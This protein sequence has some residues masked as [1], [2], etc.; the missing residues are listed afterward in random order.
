MNEKL[1][2]FFIEQGFKKLMEFVPGFAVYFIME[3]RYANAVCLIDQTDH[4]EITAEQYEQITKKISWRFVDGGCLDVHMLSLI[5]T[6]DENAAM[7][8]SGD[9]AFCWLILR[10]ENRLLIPEGRAEDFYGMKELLTKCLEKPYAPKGRLEDPVIY[11]ARGQQFYKSIKERPLVN[12][13]IFIINAL[14]F[15]ACILTGDFLYDRGVLSRDLVYNSGQWYRILTCMFLH[16]DI[17]HLVGNMMLLY[18][19]GDIVERALGHFKYLLLYL[20]SGIAGSFASM[21]FS[22]YFMDDRSSL[23]ASGAIFGMI[24]GLLWVLLRN[25]GKLEI[26]TVPK[27]LFL[28]SYSLFSGFTGSNIDNAAHVGG[29]FSGFILAILL[30]RKKRKKPQESRNG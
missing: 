28:I 16:A 30:Y 25:R 26:M 7:R 4:P 27:I 19:L 22:Y 1:E 12:H 9:D 20:G 6:D 21:A 24:G 29:L 8:L 23:G 2:D 18:F 10:R 14:V 17:T 13:A 5:L 11:D 3:N 15:T